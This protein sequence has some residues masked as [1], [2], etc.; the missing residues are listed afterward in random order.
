MYISD[1]AFLY[2]V[3]NVKWLENSP[4]RTFIAILPPFFDVSKFAGKSPRLTLTAR[5]KCTN[6]PMSATARR[7][8]HFICM[9]YA[10]IYMVR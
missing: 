3:G 9:S 8:R 1:T 4:R 6:K 10:Y 2:Y 7:H 5:G